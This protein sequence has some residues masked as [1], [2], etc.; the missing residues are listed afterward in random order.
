ME[1]PVAGG[2]EALNPS[3]TPIAEQPPATAVIITV[4]DELLLGET[5]DT[6]GAWLSRELAALGITVCGRYVV[7]DRKVDIGT[8][9]ARALMEG[10]LVL[11]TGGLGP[12]PDD[13]TRDAVAA[14]LDLP[15]RLDDALLAGLI[16]RFEKRGYGELPPSNRRQALVPEGAWILPNPV[17]TAPGLALEVGARVVA[18]LPG[19]PREMRE[20]YLSALAPRLREVY[21]GRM[22]PVFQRVLHTTGIPES[23]LSERVGDLL[24]DDLGPVSLAFLP[25]LRG[26]DLRLTIRNALPAEE[27]EAWFHRIETSLSPILDRHGFRSRSGDLSEAI[28]AELAQRSQTL[29]TAESC[30]GGLM[31]KRITDIPGSSRYFLGGLVAYTNESKLR[32]LGVP[33]RDLELRGAVS[34]EVAEAMAIGVRGRFGSDLGVAVTGIA[35][36]E[37]GSEDKPVGTVWYAVSTRDG[38]DA[39][40]SCFPGEREAVRERAAQAALALV[41]RV[42]QKG[43]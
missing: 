19:I 35:G 23:T 7:A 32:D 43:P 26:V 28:G 11:V 24:P 31:A 20:L 33:A 16:D 18:L 36:P 2:G 42:L 40:V 12:T 25:D 14:A 38:C 4:G 22:R 39:R 37:G 5:V 17:G 34:R 3:A 8:A 6:N 1:L 15:L 9:L 21:E 41:L 29:A 10:D 13:V 27:A 30:T